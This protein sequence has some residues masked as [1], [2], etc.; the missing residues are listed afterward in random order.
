MPGLDLTGLVVGNEGTFGVVTKIIVNLTRD[1]EAGRTFLGVFESVDQATETVSGLI[2]AGIV[3]A[4]LEML[5]NADDPG[6]RGGLR[7]RLPDRRR[8]RADHRGRRPGGRA[9][10]ARRRRS[11]RSSA[12]TAGRSRTRSPGGPARSRN[13]SRIWKARKGAFG[14]IGRLSPTFCTQDGVVPRTKL[15]HILRIITEIGGEARPPDRQRLPRRRRQH[16][17]DPPVRRAGRRSGPPGPAGQP[18]DP[19]RV[20]RRGRQ[21][22]GRA[23][24]RGREDGVH[25]EAV[26]GRRPGGD[27]GDPA[28]LQPRGAL[29][30]RASCCRS[31]SAASSARAP[32]TGP[33]PD[34]G[35]SDGRPG[36]AGA[37]WH[38]EQAAEAVRASPPGAGDLPLATSRA[39]PRSR[40][41]PS[42]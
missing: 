36:E 34:P 25:A 40:S 30:P 14:A 31:A 2:A 17:P 4:A 27:G 16:P 20:H 15:P 10:A 23:R 29:Q 13:M 11:P 7:L 18:R 3:P 35:R 21:R 12:P 32:G 37:R 26:L 41:S 38:R 22:H 19:R 8:R 28:G 6:R 1:P 42:G 33:R 39:G 24:H 5:D 9:R